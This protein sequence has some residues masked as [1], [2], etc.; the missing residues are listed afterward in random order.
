MKAVLHSSAAIGQISLPKSEKV[1]N[2]AR[3][4][5]PIGSALVNVTLMICLA[6]G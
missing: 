2:Y 1:D 5:Q 4:M 6:E 3:D